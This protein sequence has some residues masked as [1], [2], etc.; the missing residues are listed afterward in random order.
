MSMSLKSSV[1]VLTGAGRQN[2]IGAATA[3]LLA[4]QGCHLLINC[5]KNTQQAERV[6]E[7]CRQEGVEV[8]VHIGNL[9][10]PSICQEMK[11]LVMAKWGRVDVIVN[12]LGNTK[13]APYEKLA[14]LQ[15]EDFEKIFAVNVYAPFLIAQAFQEFI[16]QSP[17]AVVINI[18]SAAGITGKGSSIAYAAAKGA[19]NT[20]TLAL[21]QALSPEVRVNAI[22]PS[23]VD[24]SWW[25]ESFAEKEAQYQALL[26]NMK[27]NNLHSRVLKPENI[28]QMIMSV[29]LNPGI[30]GE[31]IRM[32]A[33]AHIGKANAREKR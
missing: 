18:S 19:E 16:S 32:D 12:C 5:L 30:S 23:F 10:Q 20:L 27:E 7:E 25:E 13:S 31:L 33:G 11:N 29:I 8:I 14:A 2:G 17:H 26:K 15:L 4:Q 21:A 22:C 28:A 1:A 9:T 24:S 6:A 3:R